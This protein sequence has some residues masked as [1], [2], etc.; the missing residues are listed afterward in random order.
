MSNERKPLMF[1]DIDG[2]LNNTASAADGIHILPE[3]VKLVDRIVREANADIVI[4]SSWRKLHSL[5]VIREI[6]WC[7]GLVLAHHRIIGKTPTVAEVGSI[8]G[9]EIKAWMDRNGY[10]R[11]HPHL[12]ID[13]DSDFYPYQR[14]Q[15]LQTLNECGILHE[16]IPD[17]IA[18]LRG[19]F[20]Y[21]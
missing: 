18:C 16:H 13:D 6:L 9:D 10:S 21:R 15:H 3:K 11:L 7:A 20:K 1:L 5:E 14:E 2:V 8:R 17:A 19:Q 12:I 4:S